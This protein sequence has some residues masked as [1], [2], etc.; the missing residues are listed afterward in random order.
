MR[1]KKSS[2]GMPELAKPHTV[3]GAE[4]Y[5]PSPA[6]GNHAFE[7]PY[8]TGVVSLV[9]NWMTECLIMVCLKCYL[10]EFL[11]YPQYSSHEDVWFAN[12]V[13]Q[14]KRPWSRISKQNP[15]LH[16]GTDTVWARKCSAT[17]VQDQLCASTYFVSSLS[18][19]TKGSM[20]VR[21][22]PC[23]TLFIRLLLYILWRTL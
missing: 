20:S 3:P 23:S 1:S 22:S 10:W 15:D 8:R 12:S 5:V 11:S 7:I 9:R 14:A 2:P 19:G 17:W 13:G 18:S 16:L 21:A 4:G 6:T